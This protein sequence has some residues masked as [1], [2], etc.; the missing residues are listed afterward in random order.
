MKKWIIL[1][2]ASAAMACNGKNGDFD[3]QGTFEAN[4]IMVSAEASGKL[5][6]FEV[7]EGDS[8]GLQDTVGQIDATNVTLQQEQVEASMQALQQK[9]V[10]AAPQ[11]KL[12]QEQREA[13]P[14]AP[15]FER[16]LEY[17]VEVPW[18]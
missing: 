4:E 12:F 18:H 13:H 15:T 11:V 5:L 16:A 1:T 7:Q 14:F 17:Y 2:C 9:T 8:L 6:T 3:A 10:D